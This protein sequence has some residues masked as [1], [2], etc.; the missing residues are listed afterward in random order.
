MARSEAQEAADK[1]YAQKTKDRHKQ[2]AVNF[3]TEEYDAID[4]LIK[5][6]DMTKDEFICW[7]AAR[8]KEQNN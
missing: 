3:T 4:D 8:P 1:K 5:S 6:N 7:A 2:F